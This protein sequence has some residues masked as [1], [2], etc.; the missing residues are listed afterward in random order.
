MFRIPDHLTPTITQSNVQSW[1]NL[2]GNSNFVQYA[3]QA[4]EQQQQQEI[5]NQ[6]EISRKQKRIK[7]L[8]VKY[9]K[10]NG[11]LN[12]K[13]YNISPYVMGN[14]FGNL[15]DN[16]NLP[17]DSKLRIKYDKNML[18]LFGY[19]LRENYSRRNRRN[20]Y[21]EITLVKVPI[22]LKIHIDELTQPEDIQVIYTISDE[23]SIKEKVQE[24]Q[25]SFN[26]TNKLDFSQV[27]G[28]KN[29]KKQQSKSM[30]SRTSTKS[31]KH[32]R[33][34]FTLKNVK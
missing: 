2:P 25:T 15:P 3:N 19:K 11:Y 29:N 18:Y 7:P 20:K 13:R 22:E 8:L 6:E 24:L 33:K 16:S 9:L 31:H 14:V 34:S 28:G 27:N 1:N 5:A 17:D 12:Q 10:D 4:A 30:R 32:H 21:T 26:T 23:S